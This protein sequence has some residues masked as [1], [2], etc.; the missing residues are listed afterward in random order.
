[1]SKRGLDPEVIA[2][3]DRQ[4]KAMEQSMKAYLDQRISARGETVQPQAALIDPRVWIAAGVIALLLGGGATWWF[5]FR[6]PV[7]IET[8]QN[9]DVPVTASEP[10]SATEPPPE[11]PVNRERA[12]VRAAV[13]SGEGD[14]Q[15]AVSLK[16]LMEQHGRIVAAAMR[17][18]DGNALADLAQRVEANQ[19]L[20]QAER[21]KVRVRLLE[22]IARVKVDGNLRDVTPEVLS[23]LR[24]TYSVSTRSTDKT[25]IDL[26]S[27]IILRWLETRA[28]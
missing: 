2:E 25:N 15:W 3:L 8:V 10:E 24:G 5:Y 18:A 23:K 7:E 20:T 27:E 6:K 21:A 12:T 9:I 22:S 14:G 28:R 26:Q 17:E 16:N 13:A 4:Y 19:P 11:Q 1:M